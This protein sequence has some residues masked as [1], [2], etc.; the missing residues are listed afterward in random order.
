MIMA[1]DQPNHLVKLVEFLSCDWM[2][3][4]IHIDKKI[5]VAGFPKCISKHKN[6]TIFDDN[7]RT[8][9]TWGGFS[10]VKT[11]LNLLEASLNF[12]DH[13]D[14]FCLLSG[15]DFPI[16]TLDEIKNCFNSEKEFMRVDRRLDASCNNGHCKNVRYFHLNDSPFPKI[17]SLIPK[18]N[19]KAYDKITL[20]HG[21]NWWALTEG[22]IKYIIKFIQRNNDYVS[23]HR[24]THCP[25][26]IF[27]HSIVK[28]SP[29]AANLTHDFEKA[30]DLTSYFALNEHGCHYI[31][32]N[33][34]GVTLPKVLNEGDLNNLLSS[35]ALFA[36]KFREDISGN[37]LQML[38]KSIGN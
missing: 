2:H 31:D 23:F 11:I 15:S 26:E 37:L 33:A 28:S 18:I 29:F 8:M 3:I 27:F 22:C 12:E 17:T 24:Y 5:D 9:V 7:H 36:R 30:N 1:H 6:I 35:R 14:R 34:K 38:R 4:F 10:I 16:K 20:Y 19:R 32:W 13:F 25:D 21:S